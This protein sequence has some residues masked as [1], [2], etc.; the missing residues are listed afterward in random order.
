MENIRLQ[1]D[2]KKIV[3]EKEATARRLAEEQAKRETSAVIEQLKD[4]ISGV[5]MKAAEEIGSLT[6]SLENAKKA[7]ADFKKE[8]D[9]P[10]LVVAG[11]RKDVEQ[12]TYDRDGLQARLQLARRDREKYVNAV[13]EVQRDVG[14]LQEY[15]AN[16]AAALQKQ[17]EDHWVRMC[18]N[19][20]RVVAERVLES[21]ET[22]AQDA[23]AVAKSYD[24]SWSSRLRRLK[25]LVRSPVGTVYAQVEKPGQGYGGANGARDAP[26]SPGDIDT[27]AGVGVHLLVSGSLYSVL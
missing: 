16:D 4:E 24:E 1:Q 18:H 6:T 13:E 26:R 8:R 3:E 21:R 22:Q 11:L 12:A 27:D 17:M 19:L 7:A 15:V 14:K 10:Q 9:E 2:R 23:G 20:G 25:Q 5:T